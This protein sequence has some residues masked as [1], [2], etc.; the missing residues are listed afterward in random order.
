M[1]NIDIC[2][3]INDIVNDELFE[4]GYDKEPIK[5]YSH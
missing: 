3:M 4:M 1:K 2:K 5:D